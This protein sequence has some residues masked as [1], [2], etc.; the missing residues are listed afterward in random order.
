VA[1]VPSA[2]EVSVVELLRQ[3]R[4]IIRDQSNLV[5][6]LDAYL[7][8]VALLETRIWPEKPRLPVASFTTK[9]LQE[10]SVIMDHDA[11]AYSDG[12]YKAVPGARSTTQVKAVAEVGGKLLSCTK[13]HLVSVRWLRALDELTGVASGW[14][15]AT[16]G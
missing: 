13:R 8:S 15:A 7:V 14:A 2:I 9:E 11:I 3:L 6:V 1:Y 16:T 4:I 12:A 10:I 5:S